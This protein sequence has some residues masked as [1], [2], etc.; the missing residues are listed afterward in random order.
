M[1]ESWVEGN[2]KGGYQAD[3]SRDRSWGKG[4]GI[5][6]HSEKFKTNRNGNSILSENIC[7]LLLVLNV[8]SILVH[9][10]CSGS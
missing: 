5:V 4:L 2:F 1:G 9:Y 10:K 3:S 6:V 7:D 8:F